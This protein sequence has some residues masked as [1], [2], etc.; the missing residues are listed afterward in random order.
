MRH[1]LALVM[2]FM[3]VAGGLAVAAPAALAYTPDNEELTFLA[4]INDYRGQQGLGPLTL[5]PVLGD[6]AE[7][8]SLDMATGGYFE[9]TAPNGTTFDQNIVNFGY[10][11]ISMGENIA[12]GA[13][14]ALEVM[15]MWQGSPEHNAGMLNPSYDEIG[16][17]RHYE[18]NSVYGWYWTTT[19]GGSGRPRGATE[20]TRDGNGNGRDRNGNGAGALDGQ[21]RPADADTVIA[22]PEINVSEE[23]GDGRVVETQQEI[24]GGV[25]NA[26]GQS[27]SADNGSGPVNNDGAVTTYDDINTGGVRG[28]TVNYDQTVTP[29]TVNNAPVDQ[30]AAPPPADQAAQAPPPVDQAP[31]ATDQGTTTTTTTYYDPSSGTVTDTFTSNIQEGN[32]SAREMGNTE[33]TTS[34]SSSGTVT[35]DVTDPTTVMAPPP[36]PVTDQAVDPAAAP[37]DG[38][39]WYG[40]RQRPGLAV[41]PDR[42][43]ERRRHGSGPGLRQL[44][45]SE[46]GRRRLRRDDGLRVALT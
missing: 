3:L 20:D 6:A 19:F 45:R 17:G 16:V 40:L 36:A 9:H 15:S 2:S 25:A 41:R 38:P 7:F 11:G 29:P 24:P 42:L 23:T 4:L 31:P 34:S 37:V 27:A 46:L 35:T 8:H 18:A 12:A 26:D 30:A 10:D 32:G 43:R 1:L 21:I 39:G 28:D 13:E 44:T 14:S 22:E 33:N 5:N